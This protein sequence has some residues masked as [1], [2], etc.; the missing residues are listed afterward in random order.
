MPVVIEPDAYYMPAQT[1]VTPF[2]SQ[3]LA[4]GYMNNQIGTTDQFMVNPSPSPYT[5]L[6][7][8][9]PMAPINPSAT[10]LNRDTCSICFSSG[11]NIR[12]SPCTH[13]FHA[14]CIV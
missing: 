4:N 11:T 14:N 13:Q 8:L 10:Y 9:Q 3:Q 1:N 5:A 6:P 7:H 12:L 2:I